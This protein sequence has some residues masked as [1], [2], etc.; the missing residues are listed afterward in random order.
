MSK[1]EHLV[2]DRLADFTTDRRVVLLSLMSVVTGAISA[3]VAYALLW[4]IAV[5][6]NLAYYHRFS[7]QTAS[8][9]NNHLGVW[10]VLVPV[11]GGLLIGLMARYG[12]QKIRGHG[13]PEALEAILIGRSQI[14]PK[15]A[16]LKPLSSALS[17]GTGGPFGAEGPII[18]TGGAC[19][20]LFAQLFHLSSAERKTLLVA[21]AAGGMAAV[22]ATPVA[23]VLLA[24]E[25][26]LFEWKPRS[27]IPVAVSAATAAALRVPLLGGGP[28]FPTA[29]HPPLSL[30]VLL[31][32][33][34]V[35]LAA[36]L[37]SGL[38]TALV[39][40]FEDLFSKFRLHWMWWPAIGGL[41]VGIGGLIN[42]RVLGVGYEVIHGLLRGELVGTVLL[43]LLIGKAL[44]WSFSLGSGTSGGVLAPL[45]MMGGALGAL[46]ARWIPVGD[47]GLWA[48][49]GMAAMMGGT[50]RS[51]LTAM[52]FALELTH[53]M[54]ALPGLLVGCIA[55]QGVTVL[56]LRRSILTE[57]LERRGHH[58]TRE[59]TVDLLEVARVSEVMDKNAILIPATMKV[60]DLAAGMTQ[61]ATPLVRHQGALI[62]D[63]QQNLVGIITL[64]DVLRAVEHHTESETTVLEAG[65][66][67]LIV[68]YPDELLRVAVAHM[69]N[70]DIGR[71]PVVSRQNP[72]QVVG[73]LD[74]ANVME[75][76]QR[77]F[78]EEH[79]RERPF[80]LL[81]SLSKS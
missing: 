14:E 57:K 71:L 63:D 61:E 49:I 37:G 81:D 23:A 18:M 36:G 53:D 70:N 78:D 69:L 21:G 73:Y 67:D 20:S 79:H 65:S 3:L 55:A 44:V 19:G 47:V 64:S 68:T 59:Y 75:V 31:F 45:L 72:K 1:K 13:I 24:V 11:V 76:R 52:V 33:L 77:R 46:A 10:G 51:P 54:N 6:T 7:A 16:V 15:V 74:R 22:F 62:V 26:L 32:A 34:L 12:S 9:A 60:K 50:M 40:G 28:I 41:F 35:G 29:A 38:L 58:L 2:E 39:Y 80:P 43:G 42:P 48:L 30:T 17:I 8:P 27:F 4:L 56:L 66:T 5:I 25:L